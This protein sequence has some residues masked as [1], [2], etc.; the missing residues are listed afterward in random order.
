MRDLAIF[1]TAFYD[2]VSSMVDVHEAISTH[3]DD[4][5]GQDDI[6]QHIFKHHV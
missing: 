4:G 6:T 5:W 3:R 2:V 1:I